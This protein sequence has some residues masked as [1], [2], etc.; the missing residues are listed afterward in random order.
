MKLLLTGAALAAFATV[1]AASAQT[2]TPPPAAPSATP[3]PAS[4]AGGKFSLD[5]PIQ[6]IVADERGKAVMDKN[7]PGMTALQE[8]D[9][10]KALSLRQVQPYSNGKLTDEILAKAET[11]LAAIK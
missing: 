5:T 9:M 6:D 3:A 4:T 10:F 11:D 7:F 2:A 1:S 8:Y